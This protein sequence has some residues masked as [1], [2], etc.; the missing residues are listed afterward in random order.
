MRRVTQTCLGRVPPP[1][2]FH[3]T[4]LISEIVALDAWVAIIGRATA[5]TR[6]SAQRAS[7]Q[8]TG[9]APA[10]PEV[11]PPGPGWIVGS[12]LTRGRSSFRSRKIS[13]PDNNKVG[14]R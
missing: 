12:D 7:V 13:T 5:E 2:D 11:A 10:K 14:V 1:P 9:R 8:V 6:S 4:P 3:D